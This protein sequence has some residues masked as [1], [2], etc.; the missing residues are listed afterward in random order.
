MRARYELG[1]QSL[2]QV[3]ELQDN[4]ETRGLLPEE[5][6]PRDTR[7]LL[8]F[9]PLS[10]QPLPRPSAK[11]NYRQ[12]TFRYARLYQ[13]QHREELVERSIAAGKVHVR[14]RGIIKR[15]F[16]RDCGTSHGELVWNS[17]V[18]PSYVVEFLLV[19]TAVSNT[20]RATHAPAIRLCGNAQHRIT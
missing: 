1:F 8:F 13:R 17:N 11:Q 7:I 10:T 19:P 14:H 3:R 9:D 20:I 2:A 12:N 6:C 5:P 18:S 4:S 15:E 16:A